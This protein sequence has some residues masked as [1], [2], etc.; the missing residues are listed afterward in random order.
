MIKSAISLALLAGLTAQVQA[1][2]PLTVQKLNSLNKIGNI[3]VSPDGSQLVYSL[4]TP[5]G[6]DLYLKSLT[7]PKQADTRL[8]SYPGSE[9]E[10]TWLNDGQSIYFLANR[11]ESH[12][13][14]QLVSLQKRR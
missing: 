11:K 2:E 10:V 9:S 14:W 7:N 1:A 3:S 8:T 4:K 13:V 6:S 5:D 12:Q